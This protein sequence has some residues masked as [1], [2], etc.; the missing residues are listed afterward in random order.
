M[1]HAPP[2]RKNDWKI[3][4]LFLIFIVLIM[5]Y[6]ANAHAQGVY[7]GGWGIYGPYGR[8][9][10]GAYDPPRPIRPPPLPPM[11][12]GPQMEPCIY[13]GDCRG[14]RYDFRRGPPPGFYDDD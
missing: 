10:P 13:Y 12:W 7:G 6:A 14:P 4:I 5:L 1:K 2:S 3:L 8:P 9:P 11:R